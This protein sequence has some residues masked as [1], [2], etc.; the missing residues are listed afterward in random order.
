MCGI[1]AI[2]EGRAAIDPAL[3]QELLEANDRRGPN[4]YSSVT[5]SSLTVHANVLAL[6]GPV[7]TQPIVISDNILSFNGEIYEGMLV[8]QG[9]NDTQ[10]L[11]EQLDAC[12]SHDEVMECMS[13]IKGEWAFIYYQVYP[14]LIKKSLNRLYFGRDFLGRR[15]LLWQLPTSN[16]PFIL[17]SVSTSLDNW[18]EVP[19]TGLFSFD[20]SSNHCET[21]FNY[22]LTSHEWNVTS[23]LVI[24]AYNRPARRQPYAKRCQVMPIWLR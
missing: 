16:S 9:A 22:H 5:V 11:A 12:S 13:R 20:M 10:V 4:A 15:S 21:D 7:T 17:S 8:A 1:L 6:R 24:E 14:L 23:H 19:T 18:E 2:V 3:K